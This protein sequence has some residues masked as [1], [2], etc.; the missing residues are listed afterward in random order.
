MSQI[1][2]ILV[3]R[4]SSF[5][6]IILSF[7]LLKKLREKF[8][9]TELH[10]LTKENYKEV[11][12][13]NPEVDKILTLKDPMSDFRNEIKE[14]K[15]DLILD[16]HKN[17]R[18]IFLSAFNG[19]K[20]KR[21]SKD[22]L[23]KFLLVKFKIDLLKNEVPVYKKYLNT[24]SEYISND[25]YNFSISELTF[26]KEKII[27]GEYIVIAPSSR[28]FTKTY[29]KDKF[30]NFVNEFHKSNKIQF[31]LVGDN[32]DRDKSICSY[33]AGKS[34]NVTDLCGKISIDQLAGVLY[35]ADKIITNDSAI[36]HFSEALGK[37]V[38][39]IF[40]STVKQFGF[41]PQLNGS[42]VYEIN[43]LKCRPCTHIGRDKCPEGHFRCMEE[44]QLVVSS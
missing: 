7:P 10:F 2:K 3:I 11:I 14:E 34:E 42:K 44:I 15:Y 6:D 25:E 24:I 29:P 5:G 31:V 32:S 1:K 22:N 4:L 21:Y 9:E 39:A 18:S 43:G 8:P 13:L 12:D 35:N 41:F 19:K 17:F 40:G 20:V 23:K 27:K 28:H 30:V 37:N 38:S 33:I 16:I 36:L 26:E